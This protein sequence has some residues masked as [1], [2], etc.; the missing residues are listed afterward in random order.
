MTHINQRRDTAAQWAFENPVLQNGELGWETDTRQAKLGNGTVPW[1]DLPYAVATPSI[2]AGVV[3]EYINLGLRS[4]T[5]T[6]S[7][8]ITD[9][10]RFVNAVILITLSGDITLNSPLPLG[11]LD[12]TRF[13]I[14]LVQNS[15]GG[16][17]P[18]CASGFYFDPAM[19]AQIATTPSTRPVLDVFRA[20]NVQY[21]S[22][23]GTG[24]T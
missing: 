10:L 24:Y 1:N 6:L 18:S 3:G 21:L 5:V 9:P 8:L 7:S 15:V 4:G 12:G 17:I 13:R 14:I 19:P 11:A 2:A 16:K 22:L 20:G 23:L